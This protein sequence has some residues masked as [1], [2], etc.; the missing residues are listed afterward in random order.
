M[1]KRMAEIDKLVDKTKIYDLEE[2]MDLIKQSPQPKFD[3]TVELHMCLGID[4][5]QSSQTVR[6]IV[7]L[8]Y[9]TGKQKKVC[10]I[11]K[12]EKLKE[13]QQSGADFYGDEDLIEKISKNWLEFD[14][15]VATP[16]AMKSLSKLGKMLGPKGLMPNPKAGTV[17]FDITKTVK[18]LKAGRVEFKNDSF[19]NVHC[20]VGKVSFEKEKLAENIRTLIAAVIKSK[21]SSSK[22]LYVKNATVSSTMGP[23]LKIRY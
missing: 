6:G 11:A 14:V 19:G 20:A 12:G 23:G 10:V 3:Q 7:V 16:D 5:K 18:E 2:A 9:G 15:L 22:G 8:P 13:A 21:P 4:T 1:S 17:T